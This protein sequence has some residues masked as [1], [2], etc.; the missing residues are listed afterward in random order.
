M[1]A[2]IFDMDGIIFDSERF[3]V[4][5]WLEVTKESKIL[6]IKETCYACLGLNDR[7]TKAKFLEIY[8]SDFPYDFYEMQMWQLFLNGAE[9]GKL[10]KKRGIEELLQYLKE[11]GVKIALATSTKKNTAL[12]ELEQA[13]L[14]S[15]FDQWICGDMV[16]KSKP[17]PEI[18]IK[19]CECLE[20]SPKEAVAIE[21][22]YNGI[23]SAHQAGVSVFMV[24]DMIG[25]NEEM[26]QLTSGIFPSLIE[27]KKYFMNKKEN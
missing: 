20:V 3:M 2:V 24:P 15:Y 18:Y 27:V 12:R 10:K 5:C 6:H 8:G 26:K 4:Q 23:R 16:H 19:A 7:E 25:P 14:L 17:D 22:S 21:D 13:G 1:Q 11:Q 9:K